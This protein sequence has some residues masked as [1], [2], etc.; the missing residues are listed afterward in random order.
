MRE[1]KKRCEKC[2][3]EINDEPIEL[4]GK[5]YCRRCFEHNFKKCTCCGKYVSINAP[6]THHVKIVGLS[7]HERTYTKFPLCEECFQKYEQ[8][9]ICGLYDIKSSLKEILQFDHVCSNCAETEFHNCD[10]CGE[11]VYSRD[12]ARY[13]FHMT[14]RENSDYSYNNREGLEHK[15]LCDSCAEI[16]LFRCSHCGEVFHKRSFDEILVSDKHDG[17]TRSYCKLCYHKSGILHR[18]SFKPE[19]VY[20]R[21]KNENSGILFGVENEIEVGQEVAQSKNLRKMVIHLDKENRDISIDV[22]KRM[23]IVNEIDNRYH[24]FIYQK[25]DGS[26]VHGVELVTQPASLNYLY[27]MKDG[28]KKLFEIMINHDCFAGDASPGSGMHVH[29]SKDRMTDKH[30]LIFSTFVYRHGQKIKLVAGR[31]SRKYSRFLSVPKEKSEINLSERFLRASSYSDRYVAVNWRNTNTVEV[32]IFQSTLDV[33]RFYANLEFCDA[34]YK[35]TQT[36]DT[37]SE[38]FKRNS[39]ILFCRFIELMNYEYLMKYMQS[40]NVWRVK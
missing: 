3:N 6:T 12:I 30:K 32:R 9:N 31:N 11:L 26:L 18:Y 21:R 5:F 13:D 16:N 38:L 14:P 8:C 24:D 40:I 34:V 19:Y 37:V 7:I 10:N 27:D 22:E 36:I 17:V 35:Y 29:I 25:H 20:F 2:G 39:W 1:E 15:M 23:F 4:N 28:M 33:D